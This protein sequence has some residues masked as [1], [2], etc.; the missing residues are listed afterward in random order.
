MPE[1]TRPTHSSKPPLPQ[2]DPAA[3]N[4]EA[5]EAKA[6]TRVE[7][8]QEQA[9]RAD[10]PAGGNPGLTPDAAEPVQDS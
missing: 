6:D 3:D 9:D 2:R 1:P 5:T 4:P 10:Q 8:L 7:K